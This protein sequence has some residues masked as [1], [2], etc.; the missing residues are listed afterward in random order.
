MDF[1]QSFPR[2]LFS[3]QTHQLY[4]IQQLYSTVFFVARNFVVSLGTLSFFVDRSWG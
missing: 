2:G 3:N 4:I 1:E